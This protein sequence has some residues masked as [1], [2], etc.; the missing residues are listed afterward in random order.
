MES[1]YIGFLPWGGE[2]G[3]LVEVIN[4]LVRKDRH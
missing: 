2:L 1:G 4:K 3:G